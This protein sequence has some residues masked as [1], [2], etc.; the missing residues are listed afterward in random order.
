MKIIGFGNALVDILVQIKDDELL[1][2]LGLPKGSMQLIEPSRI[3]SIIGA[4]QD[5]PVFRVSGGS[6]ANT[7]HGLAKL[8]THCG[9]AGK[10]GN[11]DLGAFYAR[12]FSDI[13]VDCTLLK[14]TN[15]T[16]RAYT[17]V[18]KDAERTFAVY[19]GAAVELSPEEITP[20]LFSGA[21]MMHVEGYQVQNTALLEKTLQT[22]RDSGVQISL[23]L[24]SYNV[25]ESHLDF[26]QKIIPRYV[27]IVFANE[28]EAKAYTGEE[29]E[30]ALDHLAKE[31]DVA[32]VK[33]GEKGSLVRRGTETAQISTLPVSVLDTTGAGDQYAAGFLHGFVNQLSLR[34]CGKLGALLAGAVIENIGARIPE[35]R[36]Q[37]LMEE[38]R[39]IF[40][41]A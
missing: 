29:P 16:G 23:D 12:D 6:A 25:V 22:A 28:E 1:K 10:V 20:A 2:N 34:Q 18:S 11:D 38:V 8:G 36:W 41:K 32:V 33:I 19:L 26:L 5:K 17:F 4:I 39:E 30:K 27:D 15:E 7:I 13:G 31:V 9:F 37:S 3:P 24:A 35:E 21:S 14:S 40:E